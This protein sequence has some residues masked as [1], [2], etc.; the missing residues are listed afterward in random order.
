V[1]GVDEVEGALRLRLLPP[2]LAAHA[3][4]AL[5]EKESKESEEFKNPRP[6]RLIGPKGPVEMLGSLNS[7]YSLDSLYSLS[8]FAPFIDNPPQHSHCS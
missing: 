4:H 7:S 2:A 3:I 5:C 1:D 8:C 6:W